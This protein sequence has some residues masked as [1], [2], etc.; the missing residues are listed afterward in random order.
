[1]GVELP[2]CVVVTILECCVMISGVKLSIR[3]FVLFHPVA[4]S[5]PATNVRHVTSVLPLVRRNIFPLVARSIYNR[6]QTCRLVTV[7]YNATISSLS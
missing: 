4:C 5:I 2:L 6:G 3:S 7:A 1:M